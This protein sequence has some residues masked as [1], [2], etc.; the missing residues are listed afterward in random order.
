VRS[1]IQRVEVV[2]SFF[3]GLLA[4]NDDARRNAREEAE[5]A[6]VAPRALIPFYLQLELPDGKPLPT[7]ETMTE[8]WALYRHLQMQMMFALDV[9][10][11]YQGQVPDIAS[12][13]VYERT[14]HDVLDAKMMMLACLEG[15]FATQEVK[16][17][18]WFRL[19]RPD[20]TLFDQ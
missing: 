10:T 18:R 15:A 7:A 14:E 16:L 3:P 5:E 4:G 11:R 2:P 6:L 8:H 13:K 20:G 12:P 19:A 17:K 1:F 9:Y